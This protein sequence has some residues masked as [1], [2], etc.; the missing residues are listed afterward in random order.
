MIQVSD[1]KDKLNKS[2]G[3]HTSRFI[4]AWVDDSLDEEEEMALNSKK[5]FHELLADRAKGRHPRTP[6]G[7]SLVLLSPS[8][9]PSSSYR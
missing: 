8:P 3:V 4:V 7:P 5:G 6:W 9:S 1:S 2:F